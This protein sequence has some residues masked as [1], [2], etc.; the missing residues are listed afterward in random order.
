[1]QGWT[2]TIR[3]GITR[4]RSTKWLKHT[5]N[6]FRKNLQIQGLKHFFFF[7]SGT[8][9]NVRHGKNSVGQNVQRNKHSITITFIGFF[10]AKKSTHEL[11]KK[12]VS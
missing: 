1:M 4:K 12:T 5:G 2:A 9:Q 10:K 8:R 6:L 7:F 11:K 3:Y